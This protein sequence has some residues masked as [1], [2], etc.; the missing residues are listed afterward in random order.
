MCAGYPDTSHIVSPNFVLIHVLYINECCHSSLKMVH[1]E[2]KLE[3]CCRH[4]VLSLN[5]KLLIEIYVNDFG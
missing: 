2:S 3:T 1:K 4:G 5:I